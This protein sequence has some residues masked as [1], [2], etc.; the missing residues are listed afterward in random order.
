MKFSLT[1]DSR[2]LSDFIPEADPKRRVYRIRAE[3]DISMHGIHEGELGGWVE[4]EGNLSKND[5]A[6]IYP[7]ALVYGE[8]IIKKDSVIWNDVWV[9][10]E[11][12]ISN[13]SSFHGHIRLAG[14]H[15]F[16]NIQARMEQM[17]TLAQ[18][19][20]SWIPHDGNQL[21]LKGKLLAHATEVKWTA[22][23]TIEAS[24][25]L[26]GKKVMVSGVLEVS[27][28][29][30]LNNSHLGNTFSHGDVSIVESY[31]V[32]KDGHHHLFDGT[33]I[34]QECSL[35]GVAYIRGEHVMLDSV[36]NNGFSDISSPNEN[37]LSLE[38]IQLFDVFSITHDRNERFR[39]Q[40]KTF[41]GE[42]TL[43]TSDIAPT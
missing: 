25:V 2:A 43:R 39:L 31:V 24:M 3:Q 29:L 32:G 35:H 22:P 9:G 1:D 5:D 21:I 23:G 34:M 7:D 42:V 8:A 41:T 15:H 20:G 14:N 13:Y 4:H 26:R 37:A 17:E 10:D 40:E 38:H 36:I 33:V 6:W 27:G 18:T 30:V 12:V 28:N 16:E 11:C 19:K